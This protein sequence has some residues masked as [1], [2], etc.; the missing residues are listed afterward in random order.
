MNNLRGQNVI[1]STN[2]FLDLFELEDKRIVHSGTIQH[3]NITIS[4]QHTRGTDKYITVIQK[5]WTKVYELDNLEEFCK[6]IKINVDNN[7]VWYVGL[8]LAGKKSQVFQNT[9]HPAQKDV[10]LENIM[11]WLSNGNIISTSY[12]HQTGSKAEGEEQKVKLYSLNIK[13]SADIGKRTG[14]HEF[15]ETEPGCYI[16]S[17]DTWYVYP[18]DL[19]IRALTPYLRQSNLPVLIGKSKTLIRENLPQFP[20]GLVMLILCYIF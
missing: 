14:I 19:P 1:D 11:K 18:T 20:E 3:K 17:R 12:Y 5:N 16:R 6:E 9:V 2:D 7:D 13:T 4:W 15:T 8:D 10:S